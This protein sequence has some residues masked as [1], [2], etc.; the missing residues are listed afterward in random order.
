M[1]RDEFFWISTI[2]KATVVVNSRSGL[3]EER[4]ARLAARGIAAVEADAAVD[5]TKRVKKYIAYEPMLIAA[6]SPEVTLIHA[7][8]SSQDILSTARIAVVRDDAVELCR[9]FDAVLD[10]LLALAE[11]H[12]STIVPNY[13]NGV[14]AQPN[15][16][17]HYVLGFVASLLR[18]RERLSQFLVHDNLMLPGFI[19][20]P[21][22]TNRFQLL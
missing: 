1:K 9:A 8:R 18:T 7:G 12:R 21:E 2:N 16:Y 13:T 11:E 5:G 17:A 19:L 20:C 3:L 15:S 14:A 4:I 6:T 22:N 10:R